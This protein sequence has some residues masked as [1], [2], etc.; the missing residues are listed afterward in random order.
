MRKQP[1]N[2]DDWLQLIQPLVMNITLK[3]VK[4][5]ILLLLIPLSISMVAHAQP[6]LIPDTDILR[7]TL[8]TDIL[9]THDRC[10]IE[11]GCVTGLGD[12]QVI[13]F[14]TEIHN[15]GNQDFYVGAPPD[16]PSHENEIWE[17]DQ[18]H[19]HWHYES[20]AQ[21]LLFNQQGESL[22]IGYKTGFCL[23]DSRCFSGIPKYSCSN[24][25]ISANCSDFYSHGLD[26]QWID[27]TDIPTGIYTLAIRINWE[28]A[29]DANGYHERDY[30]NNE[31]KVCFQLT[32]TAGGR[33]RISLLNNPNCQCP[34][35]DRDGVCS[36]DDCD[37]FNPAIPSSQACPT[38]ESQPPTNENETTGGGNTTTSNSNVFNLF[39][40]LTNLVNPNACANESVQVFYYP[41]GYYFIQVKS[42]SGSLLY[43]EDGTFYCENR[44]GFDCLVAYNLSNPLYT[45]QCD[46]SQSSSSE[47]TVEETNQVFIDFP[48]VLDHYRATT[49]IKVYT[50]EIYRFVH[51]QESNE[52]YGRLYL[53]N[54][55]FYCND[56]PTYDCRAS[57]G[58]DQ[59]DLVAIWNCPNGLQEADISDS[60]AQKTNLSETILQNKNPSQT[61]DFRVYPNPATNQINLDFGTSLSSENSEVQII[62]YAGQV[63]HRVDVSSSMNL[64]SINLQDI[65]NGFYLVSLTTNDKQVVEKLLVSK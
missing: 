19:N 22:P 55:E 23:M 11:E 44:P 50:Y 13:R 42:T 65:P 51:L 8:T 5:A 4:Q 1:F 16:H 48:W 31:A 61:T 41:S 24:Q 7:Q 33:H 32:R 43:F 52:S 28:R 58:L 57:Y 34:D 27:V 64:I 36:V 35:A 18:C 29:P 59:S 60:R 62:N 14:S 2:T 30:S 21:Y 6:D 40:W 12:R 46:Q 45:W 56:S 9:E 38:S 54:G 26:C 17:W 10:Y 63:V 15:I 25:G 53:Q 39:P 49:C 3:W 37:D 47:G 20:Y